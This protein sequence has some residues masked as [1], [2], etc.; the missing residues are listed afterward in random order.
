VEAIGPGAMSEPIES[1]EELEVAALANNPALRRTQQEAAAQWA[2]TGY[3][4]KLPDPTIS[5]MSYL[6]PM[7][8][9]PDRLVAELQVMQMIPWVERQA[10]QFA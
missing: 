7:N 6:P 9:D 8:Y 1:P 3:V 2:Q 5:S 10:T 4:S